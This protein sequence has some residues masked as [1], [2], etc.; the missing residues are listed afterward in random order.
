V[1]AE[2]INTDSKTP[3]VAVK[4]PPLISFL[5]SGTRAIITGL[6]TTAV[7]LFFLLIS[8]DLFLRRRI[9]ILPTMSAKKQV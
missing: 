7:P 2:K 1:P 6:I 9:E 3:V 5:F 4:G 8:G